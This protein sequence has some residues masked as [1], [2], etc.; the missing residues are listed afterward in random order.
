[1]V[2]TLAVPSPAGSVVRGGR[3]YKTHQR[4]RL[5]RLQTF[6]KPQLR[7][8]D[9]LTVDTAYVF[10]CVL[11]ELE[12][13]Y[14]QVKGSSAKLACTKSKSVDA[15]KA[16]WFKEGAGAAQPRPVM[17]RAEEV[18]KRLRS[19]EQFLQRQIAKMYSANAPDYLKE[20]QPG[21]AMVMCKDLI[22]KIQDD[23]STAGI[24]GELCMANIM[25]KYK[26]ILTKRF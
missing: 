1:M 23:H 20:C 14:A 24:P 21:N 4:K 13:Y 18:Q 9:T 10:Q 11:D 2:G 17:T 7:K 5:S 3:A 12:K 8:E 19:N 6:N 15:T 25:Q 26:R 22:Q 16:G